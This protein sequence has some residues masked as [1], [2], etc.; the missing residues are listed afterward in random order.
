MEYKVINKLTMKQQIFNT[1]QLVSFFKIN[2][3]AK[4]NKMLDKLAALCL[5]AA[6][7][8]IVITYINTSF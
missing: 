4:H 8:L 5:F 1:N 7:I 6:S 3:I 2:K